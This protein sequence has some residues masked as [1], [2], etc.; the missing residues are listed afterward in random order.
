ML[1]QESSGAGQLFQSPGASEVVVMAV[2]IEDE[3]DILRPEPECAD[4][5]QQ[6]IDCLRKR[7]VQQDKPIAGIDEMSRNIAISHIVD[8]ARQVERF[9]RE[10]PWISADL[11]EHGGS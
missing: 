5:L 8:V 7:R 10:F 3:T 2:D 1:S 6:Q 11:R 9:Y 4:G